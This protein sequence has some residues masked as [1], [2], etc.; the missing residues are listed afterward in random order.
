M[1]RDV[2]ISYKKDNAGNN[3]ANRLK[4][5]LESMGYSVYFNADEN[6]GDVFPEEIRLAIE[7]CKD[8]VL[9]VSQQCLEQLKTNGKIDWVREEILIAKKSDKHIVPILMEGVRMPKDK[10]DMPECLRFLPDINGLEMPE[11]YD[12]SPLDKLVSSFKSKPEK[13]DVFRD[14]SNSNP[15][16]KLNSSIAE[17]EEQSDNGSREAMYELACLYYYGFTDSDVKGRNYPKAYKYLKKL[18][19]DCT[20]KDKYYLEALSMLGE[21]SYFGLIPRDSQSYEKAL[22]YYGKSKHVSGFSYRE[23]AYMTSR[24]CGCD[25]DFENTV[26]TYREAADNGDT[27]AIV[28]LAN[29]YKIYGKFKEAEKMFKKAG[30]HPEALYELG[31]LYRNGV[32]NNPPMPDM[33][34]AAFYF[35]RAIDTGRCPPAVYHELGRLYFTPCADFP[36][37]FKAAEKYF[38]TAAEMGERHAQYKLGLMYQ[39]GFVEKDYDKAIFYHTQA[40]K[41]GIM[42]S[43]YQLSLIYQEEGYINYH[44]AYLYAK[45]AADHGVMEAEYILGML[46]FWGRGCVADIDC[47]YEYFEKSAIH[48]MPQALFMMEKI[49]KLD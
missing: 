5:N 7:G 14:T 38:L 19:D 6:G 32:L 27:V 34:K 29:T 21:M 11:V 9:I 37:D 39:Y 40:A 33:E 41:Q 36:K 8:F 1:E 18:T 24:G 26:N 3:F 43:S 42:F 30:A 48:G 44:K 15:L 10:E 28:G 17:L 25:F 12:V 13:D 35:Q 20:F 47:A 31:M 23:F 49:K 16:F 4:A 45:Q 46:L 22:V 2:F